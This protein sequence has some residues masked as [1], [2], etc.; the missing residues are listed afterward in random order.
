MACEILEHLPKSPRLL[1]EELARYVRGGGALLITTPNLARIE[2]VIKLLFAKP[3]LE[4]PQTEP[5]RQLNS[6]MRDTTGVNML[7]KN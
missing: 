2:S 6:G 1:F 5:L 7:K 4:N 3:I